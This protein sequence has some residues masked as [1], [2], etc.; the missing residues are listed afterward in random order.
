MGTTCTTKY[1]VMKFGGPMEPNECVAFQLPS[2]LRCK[3]A[4]M[5]L[6]LKEGEYRIDSTNYYTTNRGT[7]TGRTA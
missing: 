5:K 4:A 6:G 3:I 7:F 2:R 1:S